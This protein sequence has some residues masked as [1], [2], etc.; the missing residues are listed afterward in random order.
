MTADLQQLPAPSRRRWA[1]DHRHVPPESQARR[2]DPVWWQAC[3]PREAVLQR[4]L[5]LPFTGDSDANLKTR[6]RGLIKLLDWLEDQP[7]GNW[8]ERWLASGAEAAGRDWKRVPV[9]WLTA[10]D[11]ARKYD[12]IDLVGGMIPLIGGQ[13]IRP[14]YQWLLRLIPSHLLSQFRRVTDPEGFAALEAHCEATG[15][16][17]VNDRAQALN[18]ITWIM[19]RKGG[20]IKDITIGDCVELQD[21]IGE[22]QCAGQ[23]GKHLYYALLAETGV[24][25]PGAP[26]R[27]KAV[28]VLGQRSPAELIDRHEISCRPIRDL[29]VGYLT[30]RTVDVDYVTLEDMAR[31]LGLLFWKDLEQH[32][33]GISSLRLDAQ[34]AAAWKE[35]VSVVPARGSQPARPRINVHIVLSSVRAFYQDLARWAADDPARWGPWV[36]PCPI[37]DK[38][39]SHV[40]VRSRRKANMDQRTRTLLPVLPALVATVERQHRDAARRLGAGRDIPA[41]TEFVLDGET[42]LRRGGGTTGCVYIQNIHTGR[43]L[44]LAGEEERAFW[45]WAVVEVLRLT[46]VRNEEMMELTHHSFVA[47]KLPTTGEIVPMLQVAPSK[48][49][50]ERLLLVSPE[51]GEVLTAVIH[52]VRAGKAA[53]PLV[54]A[55][56]VMERTWSAPMPFLFQRRH[57]PEHRAMSRNYV[58]KCLDRALAASGLTDATGQPLRFT[59]HDFRRLFLTDAIRSG[60]PPHI[61]AKI[62]GHKVLDTTM[63]YA[64]IYPEDVITH[65]RA[66]I[67]RRRS[68]RP[69][70]E[71]RDITPGEW[72]EFLGHFE[73]RKVALGVCTRDYGTPCQHEH[74][75][76]RCPQLR[77][78]PAQ[79]PRMEEIH[80]NLLDRLHEA[81]EQGWLGEVAAIEASLA[82]AGQKLTAMRQLA[83]KHTTV[84][85]GMPDFRPDAG[86]SSPDS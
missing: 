26:P 50:A 63:G 86:R 43:R 72:Q 85:L 19:I 70:E 9:E 47:Y 60:L 56:D 58:R 36:A 42:Y 81:T 65:H 31:S 59:P 62:A 76:V 57:G 34:T 40:K 51:L 8:Q 28:M 68:L 21:G 84:H 78:D 54:S 10:R 67:A 30:D 48:L 5:A 75:C 4:T 38:E 14:N 12:T 32:H 6:E 15:R 13:V 33:P 41:G 52:R 77:P 79:L 16:R 82:A 55:Y 11:H 37:R 44:D 83:A 69:S 17:G 18:R 1:S 22:H 7:G 27:L 74:A 3:A 20:L 39:T 45:T 61:A 73:L 24:F 46:G 80:A 23:H 2:P 49:D 53:M 71:Y 64:A 35:R 29:L 25:G 66:F